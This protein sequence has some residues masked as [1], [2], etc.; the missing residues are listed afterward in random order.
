MSVIIYHVVIYH[1]KLVTFYNDSIHVSHK[2]TPLHSLDYKHFVF[3]KYVI[4]FC[5]KIFV[6]IKTDCIF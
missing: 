2:I 5:K 1:V 4:L 6:Y 3:I